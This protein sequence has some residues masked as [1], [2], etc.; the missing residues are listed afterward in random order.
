MRFARRIKVCGLHLLTVLADGLVNVMNE[1]TKG[2]GWRFGSG[3]LAV[4]WLFMAGPGLAS[5]KGMAGGKTPTPAEHSKFKGPPGP[6]E[7]A[8]EV[9]SSRPKCQTRAGE[10]DRGTNHLTLVY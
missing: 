9:N 6:L 8:G 2:F 5:D 10:Q 4:L 1:V 3:L 7:K